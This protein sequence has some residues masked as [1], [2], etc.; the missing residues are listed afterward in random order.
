MLNT[1]GLSIAPL[2]ARK[3]VGLSQR[4]F[5]NLPSQNSSGFSRRGGAQGDVFLLSA[6]LKK[7]AQTGLG[8]TLCSA[9]P[10]GL[11]INCPQ[12]KKCYCTSFLRGIEQ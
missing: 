2:K 5:W 10:C 11:C 12:T 8:D 1:H 9:G 3:S 6:D 7:M 4:C